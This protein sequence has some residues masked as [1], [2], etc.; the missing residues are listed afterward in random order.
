MPEEL[1]R[2]CD[3]AEC[4]RIEL[5]LATSSVVVHAKQEDPGDDGTYKTNVGEHAEV[6]DEEVVVKR[7]MVQDELI[8]QLSESR[9]PVEHAKCR[10]GRFLGIFQ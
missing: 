6:S 2:I 5:G 8:R 7:L 1:V 9:D 10:L 4:E 3:I